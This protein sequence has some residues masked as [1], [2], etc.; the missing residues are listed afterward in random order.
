MTFLEF[1]DNRLGQNREEAI[2]AVREILNHHR[3]RQVYVP[4]RGDTTPDHVETRRVVLE[5]LEGTVGNEPWTVFEYPVWFWHHW[6]WI[7]GKPERRRQWVRL[8]ARGFVAGWRRLADLDEFVD[9]ESV[10]DLKDAALAAHGTQ[11]ERPAD[12]PSWP[13]LADVA[14]GEWLAM[15]FS[16]RE[17]F[18]R[19]RPAGG[20]TDRA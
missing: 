10:L 1:P 18:Y 11:M 15:F 17:Y 3:D 4:Y 14:D 13:V 20:V 7:G 12:E 5:A 8:V 16:G 2:A 9:I 6:P 19:Y